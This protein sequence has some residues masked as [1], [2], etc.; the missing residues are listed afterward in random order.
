MIV[1]VTGV[2]AEVTDGSV[3]IERDGLAHE[4][5]V[6]T[7]AVVELAPRHGQA[8]TLHTLEFFEGNQVSGN[9]V[10]RMLGFTRLEDREFFQRF[11]NVKGIGPRKALKALAEPTARI[12]G[13]IEAGESK[14]LAKL[15]GI[16]QRGAELIIASLKG[17]LEDLALLTGAAPREAVLLNEAQ[18]DALKVLVAWG[19][20]RADA[21]RWLA[22]A[23]AAANGKLDSADEWVR[24]AYRVKSGTT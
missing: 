19:D 6:P 21:E 8:I 12:A 23:A 17:K 16:G 18:M 1:R 3:I 20:S 9:L 13:W 11:I 24:A 14:A 10:P 2:V 22:K 5:L 15:P 4:I 7:Y